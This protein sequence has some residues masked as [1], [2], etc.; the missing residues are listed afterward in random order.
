MLLRFAYFLGQ[1]VTLSAIGF[2]KSA[3]AIDIKAVTWAL[4]DALRSSSIDVPQLPES[5]P[6][7]IDQRAA[8][9]GHFSAIVNLLK[10]E[11]QHIEQGTYKFPYDLDLSTDFGNQWNLMNVFSQ[12][13]NYVTDRRLVIDRRNRK[14]SRE[15][16]KFY[17]GTKYP[18]YYLQ[19]FHYQSDGWLS[20]KSAELYDYQVESLFLGTA[21]AMRRQAIPHVA[22]FMRGKDATEVK[23]LDIATGTGRFASFV[24]DNFRGIDA[25]VLDLSPFYLQEAKK[26]LNRSVNMFFSPMVIN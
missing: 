8:F 4:N 7:N 11:M 2:E 9:R 18:D 14:D 3:N 25:T 6:M 20:S 26:L 21:D 13:R 16:K 23:L 22:D 12:F 5:V 17:Q 10:T 24:L 15:V 19:N 1:G